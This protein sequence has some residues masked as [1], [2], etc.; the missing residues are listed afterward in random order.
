[1]AIEQ[2]NEQMMMGDMQQPMPEAQVED[3]PI[4]IGEMDFAFLT[5]NDPAV[6]PQDAAMRMQENLDPEEQ[7][8]IAGLVPYVE[9]FF[10][11]NYKAETGEYP[12]EPN[13][14]PEGGGGI[15]I[16]E[17][18]SMSDEDRV[19]NSMSDD[20][21]PMLKPRSIHDKSPSMLPQAMPVEAPAME[22]PMPKQLVEQPQEMQMAQQTPEAQPEMMQEGGTP[23]AARVE[24]DKAAPAD[25]EAIPAGPTGEV[26]VAGKDN[27][28]V[29][30]DVQTKS[31]GFILSKGSV[32]A[33]G[34]M[35]IKDVIQKA[36]D[37][38]Q[39]KGMKL[40]LGEIPEK[41]ED[42][43]ISNGEI[44]IP[45]IIAQEIGYKRLEKMNNRGT[46]LTEKLVAE[47]ESKQQP[48]QGIAAPFK[49]AQQ[50]FS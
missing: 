29:A 11:L 3:A 34:K 49:G 8:E 24:V 13:L 36:I 41:A 38:L 19:A 35:Y 20:L 45:D 27:S 40:D 1:M 16:D 17:Y 46:E 18:R 21:K 15:T 33:N 9:R 44:M 50:N 37:N 30:D 31:D 32:I 42:I 7:K 26:N 10:V 5:K 39:K 4:N 25:K 28:G 23:K 2:Q 12:P 43:L 6:E 22:Q 48:Q 47:Y 14:E